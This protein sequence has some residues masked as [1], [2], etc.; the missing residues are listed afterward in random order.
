MDIE[1]P[2]RK[3][4]NS[5]PRC[6]YTL[7]YMNSSQQGLLSTYLIPGCVGRGVRLGS[8]NLSTG[9]AGVW[10]S[11]NLKICGPGNLGIGNP[12]SGAGVWISGNLKICRPG[13]LGIGNPKGGASVWISGNLKIWGPGNLGIGNPKKSKKKSRQR[14][15]QTKFI[16]D[17]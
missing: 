17:Y 8:E 15:P 3:L 1:Y 12:K 7:L 13:N 4:C 11:G 6:S 14:K 5:L 16:E 9:G 10:K 2:D